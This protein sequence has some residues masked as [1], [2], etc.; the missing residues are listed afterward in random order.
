M[1]Y[2][3]PGQNLQTEAVV[4]QRLQTVTYVEKMRKR[5]SVRRSVLRWR[6]CE[7]R[8]FALRTSR[9]GQG[10]FACG[11]DIKSFVLLLT[12]FFEKNLTHAEKHAILCSLKAQTKTETVQRGSERNPAAEKGF[13][14]AAPFPPL[15]SRRTEL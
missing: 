5:A 9:L 3:I 13:A 1:I 12:T 10:L 2:I 11:I 15:P 14:D 7:P 6:D 8:A 4:M